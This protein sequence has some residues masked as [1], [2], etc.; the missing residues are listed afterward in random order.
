MACQSR[1]RGVRNAGM[2][3]ECWATRTVPIIDALIV[4]FAQKAVI[5]LIIN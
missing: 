3:K 4:L 1:G 2:R 5:I